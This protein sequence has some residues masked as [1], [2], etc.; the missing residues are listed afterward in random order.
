MISFD[1]VSIRYTESASPVIADASFT[2]PD[3]DLCL[4]VG[5]TGS[6]KTTLLRAI[7]GLVP[8]F[9]GGIMTGRVIVNGRSTR[10]ERPREL[11]D[12]IGFVGQNPLAGFVTDTVEDEVAY[13]MEQLGIAATA[14][15]KR[16]EETLDL[17]N[18]AELRRRPLMQL[19]G[20]QQQRV[21]IA[22]VLAAQPRVI[23]LD[24]PTSAL[25]PTAAQDVLSA[26]TTLVHDVGM[27]AVVAEHR[28]ERVMQA[29]DQVLW[30]PGDGSATLGPAAQV[31][32]RASVVPP[33]AELAHALGWSEVPLSVRDARRRVARERIT[34]RPLAAG[35]DPLRPSSGE[36]SDRVERPAVCLRSLTV[37]HGQLRAVDELSL[38][39]EGGS[40]TALMGRNGAGKSSLMW[41]IQGALPSTGTLSVAGRDPRTLSAEA[42]RSL[43]GLVPQEAADL[44]HLHTVGL[45]CAQSDR[46]SGVNAGTTW[47]LLQRL[48]ADFDADHHP[49]DL[50][51]G[52]R[53]ALVLAIQLSAGPSVMLLDEPT[54]GLD[55]TMKHNLALI[56]RDL[57]D[58]GTCVVV[59]THDVE[60]AARISQRTIVMAEGE[61]VA[62]GP[63]R[64]VCTS[65]PAFAPQVTKV[66]LPDPVLT[67]DEVVARRV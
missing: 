42:A 22:S 6:G 43:V 21:A 52:Q 37:K 58:R 53:L 62:D 64:E 19:S 11:A 31:L 39:L 18:I 63:T 17:M 46:E 35:P 54:R 12:L 51:E 40:I 49:R 60:F 57:V 25:D 36:R 32:G 61:V 30:L 33:L 65:S 15:R 26:L 34:L 2:I 55:Y 27:T 56:L 24:E 8:H 67:T 47:A 41:A 45:E 66:F 48:G 14:M 38:T 50:S 5:G 3:G 29:A 28:L 44:L 1:E 59:S 4:V 13:G 7:N 16:V 20:G 23:V 10:A 9:V